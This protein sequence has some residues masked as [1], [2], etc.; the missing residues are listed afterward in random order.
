MKLIIL[1]LA[2]LLVPTVAAARD[3]FYPACLGMTC[4]HGQCTED[5]AGGKPLTVKGMKQCCE[6]GGTAYSSANR[7]YCKPKKYPPRAR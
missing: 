5:W 3:S 6:Y 7:I 1:A 4:T 2:V